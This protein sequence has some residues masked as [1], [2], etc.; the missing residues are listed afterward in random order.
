MVYPKILLLKSNP[1]WKE[2]V[3]NKDFIDLSSMLPNAIAGG[4][5]AMIFEKVVGSK[6]CP[7]KSIHFLCDSFAVSSDFVE[8]L[9]PPL[10]KMMDQKAESDLKSG[11]LF[12]V[13]ASQAAA[14]ESM[15]DEEQE[16]SRGRMSK[17]EERKK[18]TA[19]KVNTGGGTQGREVKTKATKKKYN[20]R[21]KKSRDFD[22]DDDNDNDEGSNPQDESV[23]HGSG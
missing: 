10:V 16:S 12:Q 14:K 17:K 1:V 8:N 2:C 7:D 5:L 22:S 11:K 3:I 19:G 13:F 21:D 18:K 23:F 6:K 4:D 20:P 9:K 15:L